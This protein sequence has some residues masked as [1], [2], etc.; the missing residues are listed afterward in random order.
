MVQG[1]FFRKFIELRDRYCKT[2][3]LPFSE[4]LRQEQLVALLNEFKV[5]YHERIYSPCVTLWM[6]LSQVLHDDQSTTAAVARL[7]AFRVAQGKEPCSADNSSYCQARQRLPGAL[8][9]RLVHD[10]GA[11][12]HHQAPKSWLAKGRPVKIVDGSTASMPDTP[13]NTDAFGK[14]GNQCGPSGFPLARFVVLLCLATGAVLESAIGPY[15]GKNASELTLFRGLHSFLNEG[16]IL[17]AD[18][19]FCSYCDL[20]RLQKQKVDTV[21]RLHASRRAD[22]R[23]GRR[24][25]PN[26]HVVHWQKPRS[27]P[28]W[29]SPEEFAAL[30]DELPMR[31]VRVR[32]SKPGYRAKTLVVVTTLLDPNEW[33]RDEIAELYRERWQAE[34]DLRSIK[35]VMHMD[36]LRC[37]TPQ[38]VRK[39]IDMHLLAYNLVRSVQCAA[40]EEHEVRVREL[41]FK[42]VKQLLEAF[43]QSLL[44]TPAEHL[45]SL[46]TTL[47]NATTQH[48][49]GNRPDR[50]EPRKRKR[51]PKPYARLKLSRDRERKLCA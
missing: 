19:L 41:S 33:S 25:G 15:R 12:L 20:A 8:V 17:L 18:R 16:D 30:P 49:V 22:F 14:P 42:G 6:F 4:I 9:H 46:C 24:L 1:R 39:E 36:V 45:E 3:E 37:E 10:T 31:E 51:A 28:D 5:V 21:V 43:Y 48:R 26:D 34:L 44:C 27:C 40:A 13:E 32:V 47:L 7:I 2:P 50:Y 38:M 23:R 11:D 35:D 29:L